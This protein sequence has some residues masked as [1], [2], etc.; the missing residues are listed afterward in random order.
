[1]TSKFGYLCIP[2]SQQT[3]QGFSIDELTFR[4]RSAGCEQ[5]FVDKAMDKQN[6]RTN[7]RRI[8]SMARIGQLTEVVTTSVD[9]LGLNSS[10]VLLLKNLLQQTL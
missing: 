7:Y 4:L 8:V 3:T 1:M 2:N 5:V 9:C 6:P 10:E